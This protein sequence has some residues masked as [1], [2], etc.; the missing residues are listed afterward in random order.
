MPDFFDALSRF[1]DQA[2]Y[3]LHHPNY[4][5]MELMNDHQLLVEV[6][7]IILLAFL[8]L[9]ALLKPTPAIEVAQPP[10]SA[11]AGKKSTPSAPP[12][13]KRTR[14]EPKNTPSRKEEPKSWIKRS[15]P[16]IHELSAEEEQALNE[17]IAIAGKQALAEMTGAP[18]Q[19]EFFPNNEAN[20]AAK[21]MFARQKN[22]ANA[23]DPSPVSKLEFIIL[24]FMAPRSHAFEN[25]TLFQLLRQ[26]GLQLN[27]HRVF[28]YVEG[29]IVQFYVSSALKPGHFDLHSLNASV[30]GVCF[31]LD[32]KNVPD[33]QTAFNAM[34][35]ILHQVS[36]HLRGDILDEY[37]QRLTQSSISAYMARIK[38][39]SHLNSEED[40]Q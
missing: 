17:A 10:K 19:A 21:K 39:F 32:L 40:R 5:K 27:D 38:S 8:I 35:R 26:L 25:E 12:P 13:A 15:P 28:E 9:L 3:L 37:R 4:I 33:G 31:V 23:Q 14:P 1:K 24:Y 34:L 36:E 18:H 7:G 16:S 2:L 22:E 20:E 29:E 6:V 11:E 30:P